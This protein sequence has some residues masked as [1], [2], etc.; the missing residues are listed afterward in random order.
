MKLETSC[1]NN[2]FH[3]QKRQDIS[4]GTKTFMNKDTFIAVDVFSSILKDVSKEKLKMH[5]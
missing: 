1:K 4:F 3:H 2:I 5:N